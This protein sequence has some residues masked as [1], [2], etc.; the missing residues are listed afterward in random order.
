M[1]KLTKS[2]IKTIRHTLLCTW[3]IFYYYLGLFGQIEVAQ[4]CINLYTTIFICKKNI[5]DMHHCITYMYI[6]FQRNLVSRLVK[7][8]YT[9]LFAK[10]RELH[11]FAYYQI[12]ILKIR[13]FQTCIIVW[14]T[15]ISIFSKIG[16]V[17]RPK[18]CTQM[19]LQN[20]ISYINLQLPIVISNK[21]I[22]ADIHHRITYM[23]LNF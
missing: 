19:Y 12:V 10:H 22:I 1:Q 6:H 8:V 23:Y 21:S 14:H 4:Y 2:K 5:S 20:I 9:N 15:S 3:P 18:S 13:L 16:L 11:K 7:T 17:D